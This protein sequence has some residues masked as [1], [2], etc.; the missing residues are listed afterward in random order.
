MVT[1]TDC[2]VRTRCRS[3][4][5]STCSS[6]DNARSDDSSIPATEPTDAVRSP[7]ATATASSSSSSS[8]GT[9]APAPSR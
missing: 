5:G 2:S 9:F 7:T 8:G 6:F 4:D 3:R 1:V